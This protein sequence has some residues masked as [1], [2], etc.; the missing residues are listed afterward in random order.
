MKT[1]ECNDFTPRFRGR[2]RPHGLIVSNILSIRSTSRFIVVRCDRRSFARF[3][4]HTHTSKPLQ[5][6]CAPRAHESETSLVR[7]RTAFRSPVARLAVTLIRLYCTKVTLPSSVPFFRRA[8]GR[9]LCDCSAH[10]RPDM[11]RAQLCAAAHNERAGSRTSEEACSPHTCLPYRLSLTH[12]VRLLVH[13]CARRNHER[14]TSQ[15]QSQT[16]SR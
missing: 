1:Y 13:F 11:G 12:L 14:S 9:L 6:A 16:T 10:R 8:C 5:S 7:S 3:S 4:P 2:T 15:V